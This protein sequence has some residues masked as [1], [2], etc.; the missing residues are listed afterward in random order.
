MKLSKNK[1]IIYS[2]LIVVVVL[3]LSYK[4]PTLARFKN[5]GISSSNV[6]SGM[7][8]SK[9]RSGTGTID[10]PYIISNG[11]E[12]AF[13]SSQLENN[14][15]EDEYFKISN[16]ILLNEG[17]FKYE[18]DYLKYEINGNSYYL[19]GTDYYETTDFTLDRVGSI[20]EFP[21][22]ENFKGTLDGDSHVIYGY[23]NSDESLYYDIKIGKEYEVYGIMIF[24]E[25]KLSS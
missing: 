14:N 3:L 20:N 13:F 4:I 21:S 25:K 8:A 16:D 9:Y 12:L 6:W 23:Y 18:N 17:V 10:D 7:V 11:D 24:E 19:N 22:L 15:Y 1:K 2:V 5:R